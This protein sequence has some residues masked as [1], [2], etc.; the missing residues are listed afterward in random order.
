MTAMKWWGRRTKREAPTCE[1]TLAS[2]AGPALSTE[3]A[4]LGTPMV[5]L[6]LSQNTNPQKKEKKFVYWGNAE[7]ERFR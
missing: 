7:F 3:P 6:E 5:F 1:G 2:H 4:D